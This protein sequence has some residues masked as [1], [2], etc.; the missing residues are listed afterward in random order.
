MIVLIATCG[1]PELLKRT[2]DSLSDVIKPD[3]YTRTIIIE[4][5]SKKGIDEL[6]ESYKE[7]LNISYMFS[8]QANKSN[9]LNVAMKEISNTAIFF[10]D[11]D[12]I[13][14]KNILTEYAEAIKDIDSGIFCGGSFDV[15]YEVEPSDF[16]KKYMPLSA[17][18][19][20]WP[21]DMSEVNR[22]IFLGCNWL[23]FADDIKH[24]GGFDL[25]FGP[26]AAT[27][28]TGQETNM[29][30]R[31]LRKGIKGRFVP[32]AKV[33]HFVPA[34]SCTPEW[35]IKRI[36]RV[37]I[38]YGLSNQFSKYELSIMR[39][40]TIISPIY[41]RIPFI[42]DETKFKIDYYGS[43]YRGQLQGRKLLRKQQC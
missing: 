32:G 39:L 35:A 42:S 29:Q 31:L 13:F 5:G 33:K 24:A 40:K 10:S 26:G 41:R 34:E 3:C 2:L 22:P 37:G 6:T 36:H 20:S 23:A 14:D 16:L 8:E 12:I 15:D 17:V 4:N 21:D 1:R 25:N 9:A 30:R 11:D 27:N 19:S 28:S 38:N 18:G 43:F 7:K